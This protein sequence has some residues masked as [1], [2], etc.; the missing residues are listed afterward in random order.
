MTGCWLFSLGA[1]TLAAPL[2]LFAVALACAQTA[3]AKLLVEVRES[4]AS[5]PRPHPAIIQIFA[6]GTIKTLK[7]ERRVSQ[8]ALT[9]LLEQLE[10]L[11]MDRLGQATLDKEFK[12]AGEIPAGKRG[13]SGFI[14]LLLFRD[15]QPA[16]QLSLNQP[17]QF[18]ASKATSVNS[19]VKALHLIRELADPPQP[20]A[21][22]RNE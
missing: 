12:A 17:D 1:A 4:G 6:D 18:A 11:G 15:K 16:V 10:K 22:G 14:T 7:G 20:K 8:E 9:K 13:G 19:F 5:A 3:D 21:V 2:G